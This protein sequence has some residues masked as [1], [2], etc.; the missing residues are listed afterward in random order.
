MSSPSFFFGTTS[1]TLVI[2]GGEKPALVA[3]GVSGE[4]V[5]WLSIP[6]GSEV[7]GSGDDKGLVV[8]VA[9]GSAARE[10]REGEASV[11]LGRGGMK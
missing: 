5:G 11:L 1:G 4:G 8:A 7:I 6:T 10:G 3:G 2:S 9:G